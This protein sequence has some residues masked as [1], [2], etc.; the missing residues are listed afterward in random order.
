[1]NETINNLHIRPS[2]SVYATYQRLSYKPWYAI[3]EFVDNSTHSYYQNKNELNNHYINEK[4]GMKVEIVYD[5][6]ENTLSVLDNAYGMEIEDFKR[7]IILDS[8]PQDRTGRSEF[9][10]GLK[11][12]ACWFGSKWTVESTMLGSNNLYMATIDVEE[13]A[14]SKNDSIKYI[15]KSTNRD[16]HYTKVTIKKLQH[17]I[18]GRSVT[19]VQNHLASIYRQDIRD[20][21]ISLYWNGVPLDYETPEFY[22][23]INQSGEKI[24]YKKDV[25]FTVPW[26]RKNTELSVEGWVGIRKTGKQN[27]AGLALLRR[28]R[29]ILGGPGEG[30]KPVEVF[31]QGNT[32]SS[33]RLIGELHLDNWPVT[34][35]KDSFDW[36]DGLEDELVD[37]LKEVTA[38][39]QRK[40]E[41][42]RAN[43]EDDPKPITKGTI[44]KVSKKTKEILEKESFGDWVSNEVGEKEKTNDYI[45]EN[46]KIDETLNDPK[47]SESVIL[48]E[49]D[50]P[51]TYSLQHN[52]IKWIFTLY[53]KT[54]QTDAYWLSLDYQ[55]EDITNMYL[56]LSHPFL[57]NYINDDGI[58]EMM[59]KFSISLAMAEKMAIISSTNKHKLIEPSD[60]RVYMNKVLR[61]ISA[62]QMEENY[63]PIENQG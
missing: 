27:E 11:T 53:W 31:G 34:Q 30:Y 37:K 15:N 40:A 2:T 12:A 63:E 20:R 29:V 23:E 44:E 14:S 45:E 50:G 19:K 18:K 46:K 61:K 56:N 38:E 17:P 59:L 43:K 48:E 52:N 10:M 21:N 60:M 25:K 35:A 22:S 57:A 13:L 5:N 58:L 55:E 47:R 9:G 8:P 28:G 32:F 1:M 51:V 26:E 36:A 3:A 42:I 39:Y 4:S 6:T 49:N 62:L 16:T 33:Q 54:E 41:K 24:V 7:A